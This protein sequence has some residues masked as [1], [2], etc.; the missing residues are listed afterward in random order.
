MVPSLLQIVDDIARNVVSQM[1]PL[2]IGWMVHP[3]ATPV[4]L[5]QIPAGVM[6]DHLT[7]YTKAELKRGQFFRVDGS[8]TFFMDHKA[9][10][11]RKSAKAEALLGDLR[12]RRPS[13]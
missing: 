4:N 3:H 11:K 9:K 8:F 10:S 5:K 7:R 12:S 1:S 6:H 13:K 2:E